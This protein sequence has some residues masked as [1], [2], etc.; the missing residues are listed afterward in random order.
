[1]PT[2]LFREQDFAFESVGVT[3]ETLRAA[4]K[5]LTSPRWHRAR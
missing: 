4:P 5:S 2:K 1:L 3:K